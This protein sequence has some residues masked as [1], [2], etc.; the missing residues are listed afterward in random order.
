[1]SEDDVQVT[2]DFAFLCLFPTW[3]IVTIDTPSTFPPPSTLLHVDYLC[4]F[5]Y[6]VFIL[7]VAFGSLH[8]LFFSLGKYKRGVLETIQTAVTRMTTSV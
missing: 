4:H 5:F 2:E 3:Y 1:M 8:F 7:L 6:G